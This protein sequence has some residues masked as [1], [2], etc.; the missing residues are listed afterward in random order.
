MQMCLY[1]RPLECKVTGQ[2]QFG[3][4]CSWSHPGAHFL[5]GVMESRFLLG[6][7]A[8]NVLDS[9]VISVW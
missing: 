2:V 6:Y 9:A 4:V 3:L 1:D 7:F 5:F 8:W